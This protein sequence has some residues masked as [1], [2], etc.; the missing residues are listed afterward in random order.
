MSLSAE[1]RAELRSYARDIYRSR[2]AR[3]RRAGQHLPRE[4]AEEVL[5]KIEREVNL[6]ERGGQVMR[7]VERL[8]PNESAASTTLLIGE[9]ETQ[10]FAS[11]K[12]TKFFGVLPKD[13][14]PGKLEQDLRAL[15]YKFEVLG[16]NIKAAELVELAQSLRLLPVSP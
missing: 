12:T 8:H 14:R 16:V 11:P 10:V 1:A 9:V 3:A 4:P 5:L 2:V 6:N 15:G 7:D 13:V